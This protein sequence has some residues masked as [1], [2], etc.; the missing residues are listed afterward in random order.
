MNVKITY[1]L[2]NDDPK[3]IVLTGC[4]EMDWRDMVL[5]ILISGVEKVEVEVLGY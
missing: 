2:P 1:R 3:E 4:R 5:S